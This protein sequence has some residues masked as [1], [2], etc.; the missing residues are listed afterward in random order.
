MRPR[1]RSPHTLS[2]ARKWEPLLRARSSAQWAVAWVPLTKPPTGRSPG[3]VG[4]GTA[5]AR[6]PTSSWPPGASCSG[7]RHCPQRP[8][9]TV[10]GHR[11]RTRAGRHPRSP[12]RRVQTGGVGETRAPRCSWRLKA[13]RS[14]CI[15]FFQSLP[16]SFSSLPCVS[17]HPCPSLVIICPSMVC[18]LTL[19]PRKS[20]TLSVFSLTVVYPRRCGF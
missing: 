6:R 9:S 3:P 4:L 14:L 12:E 1:K 2:L 11:V 8:V 16:P 13:A 15:S 19:P 17:P 10:R 20:P 18:L 7:F 5:P